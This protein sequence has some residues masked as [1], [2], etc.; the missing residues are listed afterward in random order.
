MIAKLNGERAKRVSNQHQRNASV[1]ALVHLF[2]EEEER[3]IMI[4]MADMQKQ[5]VEEEVDKI[6]KMNEWK[7]RVLGITREEIV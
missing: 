6:E 2:Q 3:R 1:L 5:S 4:K 7:A